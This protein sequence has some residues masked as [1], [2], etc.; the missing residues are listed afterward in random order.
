VKKKCRGKKKKGGG[1]FTGVGKGG[2]LQIKN[3]QKKKR[4]GTTETQKPKNQEVGLETAAIGRLVR[5]G[6]GEQ[7]PSFSSCGKKKGVT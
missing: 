6:G 5:G 4:G 3:G 1:G 7:E 2:N